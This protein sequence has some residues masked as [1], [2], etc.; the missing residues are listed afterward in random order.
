MAEHVDRHAEYPMISDSIGRFLADP[1]WESEFDA[2]LPPPSGPLGMSIHR[3]LDSMVGIGLL[4]GRQG[5]IS[6]AVS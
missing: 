2:G 4:V 1:D 3:G 6:L 5:Q